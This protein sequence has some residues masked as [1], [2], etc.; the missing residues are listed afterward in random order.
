VVLLC[1]TVGALAAQQAQ[2][3]ELISK[4]LAEAPG[5]EAMMIT[6]EYPPA[7]R[8]CTSWKIHRNAGEGWVKNQGAPMLVPLE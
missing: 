8:S 7:R 4:G 2:V 1:L 6:V 5:K 3:T